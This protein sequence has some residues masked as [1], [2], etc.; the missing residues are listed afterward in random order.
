MVG[1]II[2]NSKIL[3]IIYSHIYIYTFFSLIK[4][5]NWVKKINKKYTVGRFS[6]H[7]FNIFNYK[8]LIFI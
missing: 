2:K 4:I 7:H 6:F 3:K 1:C 8:N 5:I